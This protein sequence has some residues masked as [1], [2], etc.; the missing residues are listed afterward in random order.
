MNISRTP[1]P[2]ASLADDDEAMPR[3]VLVVD[4]EPMVRDTVALLL[5]G[6]DWIVTTAASLAEAKTRL[7]AE[8]AIG[9]VVSDVFL[10]QESG[11][12]LAATI[13][14]LRPEQLATEI[15]F[16]TGHAT[17]ETAI[18]AL[19][20]QAFDLIAKPLR[21]AD[22]LRCIAAAAQS[23]ARRRQ[24][25]G[26]LDRL[27]QQLAEAE[28]LR[29]RL[30]SALRDTKER[31]RALEK[32]V[33]EARHDLLAVISHELKTPLIPIVGLSDILLNS[34]EIDAAE[35]RQFAGMIREGG[36]RLGLIIDRTL[37]YLDAERQQAQ[38]PR[39]SFALAGLIAS[40]MKLTP[41][42]AEG[43]PTPIEVS[44]PPGLC[45]EGA[46][47]LLARAL[48]EVI[49]NAIKASADGQAV[50]IEGRARDDG[51]VSVEVID[52]G[53]GL[54]EVVRRNLGVPFLQGDASLNRRWDGV[55]IGLA[56]AS[57]I[58]LLNGGGLVATDVAGG[59]GTR[60]RLT[61]PAIAG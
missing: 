32:S 44:C 60:V 53:P 50:R 26:M 21:R 28:S 45:A 49:D 40:A 30:S 15:V 16:I 2:A 43:V 46:P 17:S 7:A 1:I 51:G 6:S 56:L 9:V 36:E 58:A 61:L 54:P 18:G 57:K 10:A 13:A 11:F 5:D 59:A 42:P 38:A 8:P 39:E 20:H 35:V 4:D 12:D 37:G 52:S 27:Q 24:R 25:Q 19:R 33:S 22:L 47:A 29:A 34:A 31:N 41:Q 23:A 3:G 55:G 48:A 14:D